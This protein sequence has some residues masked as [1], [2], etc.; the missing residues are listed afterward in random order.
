[1]TDNSFGAHGKRLFLPG[2]PDS[3]AHPFGV[4]HAPRTFYLIELCDTFIGRAIGRAHRTASFQLACWAL[5]KSATWKV[6]IRERHNSYL[7]NQNFAMMT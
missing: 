1:M 2:H 5:R 4:N 6:A 3:V 7:I